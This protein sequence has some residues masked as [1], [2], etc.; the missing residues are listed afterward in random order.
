MTKMRFLRNMNG[1]GLCAFA[2]RLGLHHAVASPVETGKLS[3]PPKWRPIIAKA[4]GVSVDDI[5]DAR[6]FAKEVELI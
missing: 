6:G 1:E 4:L 2:R 5:F 3:C